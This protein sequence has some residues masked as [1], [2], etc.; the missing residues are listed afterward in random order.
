MNE[1]VYKQ[2]KKFVDLYGLPKEIG[3]VGWI[4]E[5]SDWT[6]NK[7]VIGQSNEESKGW[8]SV[9]EKSNSLCDLDYANYWDAESVCA[10]AKAFCENNCLDTQLQFIINDNHFLIDLYN[11]DADGKGW[12]WIGDTDLNTLVRNL[13]KIEEDDDFDAIDFLWS[14]CQEDIVETVYNL[15]YNVCHIKWHNQ[16]LI[17]LSLQKNNKIIISNI[18]NPPQKHY[19]FIELKS[20]EYFEEITAWTK[21]KNIEYN[22]LSRPDEFHNLGFSFNNAEHA[23][24]FTLKWLN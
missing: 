14:E 20:I 8:I 15:P 11:E 18:E 12:E 9:T 3:A 24:M 1:K 21:E 7:K 17:S 13:K 23:T 2:I 16:A 6:Y 4:S 10:I 19:V 5:L 22:L